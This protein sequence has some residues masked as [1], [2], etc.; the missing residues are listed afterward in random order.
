MLA[1]TRVFPDGRALPVS[2][3]STRAGLRECAGSG[4]AFVLS[5]VLVLFLSCMG[6]PASAAIVTIDN[7]TAGGISQAI[8]AAGSGGIVILNPGT[9]YADEIKITNSTTIKANTSRGGSQANTI[10]DGNKRNRIFSYPY[11][12]SYS[13]T[14]ENLTLANGIAD[15]GGAI[16][17]DQPPLLSVTS[18]TF[19]N[20]T[21]TKSDSG[22][23]AIFANTGTVYINSTTFINC[24]ASYGGAIHFYHYNSGYINNST[25]SNCSATNGGAIYTVWFPTTNITTS[26]FTNCSAT[27]RGGAIYSKDLYTGNT[28]IHFSRFFR[29]TDTMVYLDG[30]GGTINAENNWW[31]SNTN[32]SSH[33]GGSSALPDINPWLKLGITA[34]P[35]LINSSQT[36][37]IQVNL[38]FNSDGTN[39][40]GSGHVPDGIPVAFGITGG[41]GNLLPSTGNLTCGANISTFTPSGSETSQVNG[42]VDSESQ[43]VT[44]ILLNANFTGTPVSGTVPLTVSFTDTSGGSPAQWNWSFG[45]GSWSNTTDISARSPTHKYTG[46]G[47]Y[48][49]N[50]TVT[51]EGITDMLSRTGYVTVTDAPV[52]TL[53]TTPP[54]GNE[55]SS[56]ETGRAASFAASSYGNTAGSAMNFAINEPLSAGNF[57]YSYAIISVSIVP[58]GTLGTTDLTVTDA[59]EASH[60][61]DDRIIT[62]IVSISP[63]AVNPSAIRSGTITFAVSG[64]WLAKYGMKPPDIVLMRFHEGTW[65]ELP[66]TY[67]YQSG[68]AYYFT[69]TTPGFSYFAIVA[70]KSMYSADPLAAATPAGVASPAIGSAQSATMSTETPASV[71]V[72]PVSLPVPLTTGT[73]AAPGAAGP[74]TQPFPPG[75]MAIMGVAGIAVIA[76]GGLLVRWWIRMKKRRDPLWCDDD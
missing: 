43:P 31:G 55:D 29:N 6:T 22:G 54:A 15:I 60:A 69:A 68:N 35:V 39:T 9:Y 18:C 73:A 61:P 59:G 72:I 70:R 32:P 76:G 33:A 74:G 13:L 48:T 27:N 2:A 71:D 24:S 37:R 21:A 58:S 12:L 65:G 28:T 44:I 50:L 52:T 17:L 5:C 23:G 64:D 53:P 38:T 10:I 4:R 62:G 7:T 8:I 51:R 45:D 26:T 41:T 11:S 66:T 46:T 47:T 63:V 19:I 36:A 14:L 1:G 40:T 3:W 67:L 42:T 75:F 57:A 20:C 56:G 16:Y 25:F 30:S 34:D 49:I